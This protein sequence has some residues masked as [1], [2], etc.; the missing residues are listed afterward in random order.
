M[1]RSTKKKQS[2]TQ[3][4][5]ATKSRKTS[6]GPAAKT[7]RKPAARRGAAPVTKPGGIVNYTAAVRWLDEHVNYERLRVVPY[8][9]R[10][11]S[12]ERTRKLLGALDSPHQQ[13]RC[14]Q[15]A[16]GKG[17][18]STCAMLGAMLRQCG[19]TVGMYS[20][21]HLVDLCERISI[22]EQP[23]THG[24]FVDLL[25]LIA[26]KETVLGTN[27]PSYFE[28]LTVAALRY[29]ADQAVDVAVLETGMGGRLDSTTVVTPLVSALTHISLDHTHILGD[30]VAKIAR[31]K[32]GI[33]KKG[34]AAVSV[35]QEPSVTR[36]LNEVASQVGAD[37]QYVGREIE[38]SY[39]FEASR[40]LGPHTRVGVATPTSRW[41]HLPVPL[42]GEHQAINCGL[43]L[44]IVDK[45]KAHDFQLTEEQIITGLTRTQ[46]SGRMEQVWNDPRV[47]IDGAHNATSI[48][49]LIRALG[50]HI[51]YDSLIMIFGCGQD[52]DTAGMLK[53]IS[54][55]ADKV[56]FT[57]ARLSP[58]A[59]EPDEL[60]GRF[61]D[62]S[63][64]MAQSAAT[65]VRRIETGRP[66]GK[67]RGPDR[68]RGQLLPGG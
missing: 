35:P 64:K 57:R 40:D 61:S 47:I 6:T 56:I 4:R 17:K 23:I 31:E 52:K 19:Y 55:G 50:A 67:P 48:S 21:P 33:F 38:F 60:M 49:A 30:T 25:K 3:K 7:V 68:H 27:R 29:F 36:V 42:R 22:D 32:A 24:D 65:P 41:D 15:V 54:L 66:G 34:V 53:Q 39:R 16:G 51:S 5:A 45:L 14:V 10:T 37:L 59:W 58:R 11:F 20:S 28:V 9:S 12:L 44:A 26:S 13:L 62:F 8:N 63:G 2:S 43:A 18:G 46:L 1:A